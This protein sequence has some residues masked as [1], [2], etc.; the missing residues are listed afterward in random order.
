MPSAR[1]CAR[2]RTLCMHGLYDQLKPHHTPYL[3]HVT[4]RHALDKINAQT[5]NDSLC[6]KRHLPCPKCG[7]EISLD[8]CFKDKA[9]EN[10]LKTAT[11]KCT[12]QDCPWEGSSKFYKVS[13][14][15]VGIMRRVGIMSQTFNMSNNGAQRDKLSPSNS[16][17]LSCCSL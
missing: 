8:D 5:S 7:E 6:R 16:Q 17:S 9:A 4:D 2:T 10:E 1:R 15:C 13:R 12:N 3:V 14:V 11:I